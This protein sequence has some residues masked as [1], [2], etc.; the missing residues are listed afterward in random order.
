ML[1]GYAKAH[2]NGEESDLGC[3]PSFVDSNTSGMFLFQINLHRYVRLT[4]T[5]FETQTNTHNTVKSTFSSREHVMVR[6]AFSC[7]LAK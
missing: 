1:V 5:S 3:F 7:C 6:S 4:R 2:F